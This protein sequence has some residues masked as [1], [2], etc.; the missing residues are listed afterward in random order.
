MISRN[1][2]I[3]IFKFYLLSITLGSNLSILLLK[4]LISCL[5]FLSS[6]GEIA[7]L[8]EDD[9]DSLARINESLRLAM[10]EAETLS[11]ADSSWIQSTICRSGQSEQTQAWDMVNSPRSAGSGISSLTEGSA[12]STLSEKTYSS[13]TFR[14]VGRVLS[15]G[16]HLSSI[17]SVGSISQ[18]GLDSPADFSRAENFSTL[19][20]SS[21]ASPETGATSPKSTLCQKDLLTPE[22]SP[23][24]IS[25]TGRA[26]PPPRT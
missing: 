19:Q 8:A 26:T 6:S 25:Q 4:I 10:I 23:C 15:E 12:P 21:G 20:S 2:S 13:G 14:E 7:Y 5:I 17:V 9:K 3:L 22:K 11:N 1:L 18:T 16:N 24:E